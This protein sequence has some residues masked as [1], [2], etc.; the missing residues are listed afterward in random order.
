MKRLPWQGRSG[1]FQMHDTDVL[2]AILDRPQLT[3][4]ALLLERIALAA[5]SSVH[6][7][8]HSWLPGRRRPMI[9][10]RQLESRAMN[11]PSAAEA[12]G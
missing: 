7:L 4:H 9:I 6:Q 2:F 3:S 5:A 8:C 11:T 12:A 10:G 1:S